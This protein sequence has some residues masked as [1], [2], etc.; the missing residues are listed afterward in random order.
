VLVA[1]LD[2][3]EGELRLAGERNGTA[4]EARVPLERNAGAVGLGSTWAREK[5]GALIDTLREGAPEAEV[6]SRVIELASAH[7]LVTKYTSF[8]AVDKTPARAPEEALKLAEVPTLLPEGWEYAKVYGELPRG[9]TDSRLALITG[10][11]A[12]L[13]G[14]VLLR[15]RVA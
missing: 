6:R 7:R 11:G 15:R 8:V 10:L 9:A 1:R 12:M 13:L 2:R 5:V 14:L 4:W 3:L